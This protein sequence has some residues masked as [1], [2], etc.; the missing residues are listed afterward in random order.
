MINDYTV[1]N[2]F[3]LGG[4]EYVIGE[5]PNA[6]SGEKYLLANVTFDGLFERYEKCI[7]S[8]DYLEIVKEY[9]K[10]ITEKAKV[11]SEFYKGV[12]FDVS[13][14]TSKNCEK[15]GY[16]REIK[17]QVVVIKPDIFYPENQNAIK[18]LCLCVSG[19]GSHANSRGSA[20]FCI[21]LYTGKEIRYERRDILGVIPK[22]KLPEWAKERLIEVEKQ[23]QEKHRNSKEVR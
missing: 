13:P 18:Q 16:D 3:N 19:F 15:V 6:A 10:R 14:I 4:I 11:L 7:V 23:T 1:I 12:G 8:D 20:C 9:T 17:G 5:N 22:D 21:N 2:S